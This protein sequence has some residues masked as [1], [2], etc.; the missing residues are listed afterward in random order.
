[1]Q[2]SSNTTE[3]QN[4]FRSNRSTLEQ[5][6]MIRR[7]LERVK[8]NK[9][10]IIL[11]FIDS[12]KAFKSINSEQMKIILNKYGILTEIIN[13]I[14][15]LYINTRYMVKSP[16]GDSTF[17]EITNGVLHVDTRAPLMFIV[18]LDYIL[19]NASEHNTGL[20]FTLTQ[21]ISKRYPVTYITYIDYADD[22]IIITDTLTN[23]K[24][25]LQKSEQI[26]DDIG[27]KV[28]RY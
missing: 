19:K 3:N 9:I 26:S 10:L 25:L 20:G 11:L 17:F 24:T 23:A 13:A 27:L 2:N 1:M 28:N 14:I 22:I 15:M 12:S 16:D 5:I 18:C 4:G 21:K 8:A 6:L 7:I